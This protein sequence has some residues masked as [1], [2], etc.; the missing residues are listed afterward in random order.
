MSIIIVLYQRLS[1]FSTICKHFYLLC[2]LGDS[3]CSL[4]PSLLRRLLPKQVKGEYCERS[5]AIQLKQYYYSILWI[6]SSLSLLAMT[7]MYMNTP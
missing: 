4:L 7:A 5:E 1:I 3:V 6:A 2:R